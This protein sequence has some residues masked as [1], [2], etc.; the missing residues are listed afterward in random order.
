MAHMKKRTKPTKTELNK[1]CREVIANYLRL[2]GCKGPHDYR[3]LGQRDRY[4]LIDWYQC[5]KCGGLSAENEVVA[6]DQGV[7]DAT[8]WTTHK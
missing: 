3:S 8:R 7:V 5:R 1:W 4:R 6:Y 2:A